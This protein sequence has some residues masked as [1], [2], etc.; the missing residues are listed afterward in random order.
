[1][2]GQNLCS[3]FNCSLVCVH[4]KQQCTHNTQQINLMFKTYPKQ[5][6]GSLLLA[7]YRGIEI[8]PCTECQQFDSPIESQYKK[9]EVIFGFLCT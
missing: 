6:L 9:S 5:L 7:C 8:A 3:V 4:A 1:M 2:I